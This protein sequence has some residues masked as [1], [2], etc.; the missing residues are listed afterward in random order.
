M[1][2]KSVGWEE[3]AKW[4]DQ[5]VG[6]AGHYYHQELIVPLLKSWFKEKKGSLV[7]LGCGQ[8]FFA[9]C[10]PEGW[11]YTGYDAAKSLVLSAKKRG[12]QNCFVQDLTQ[13]IPQPH[14]N[15]DVALFLLSLQDMEFPEKAI[16]NASQLVKPGKELWIVLNHPCF[17]IPRQSSWGNDENRKIQYRRVDQYMSENLIPIEIHPS[18]QNAK[19]VIHH[20][21]S[22]TILTLWLAKHGFLIES[23]QE[24][25]SNKTSTGS[26]ASMENRARKEFPLFMC[27]KAQKKQA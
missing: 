26:K 9:S 10:L 22:L 21:S 20:H 19:K 27:I 2:K 8:A 14:E 12:I 1:Q 7:D 6:D 13:P 18:K 17:R 11:K 23:I 25:T 24:L 3:G 15:F 4:Y 5:L 16:Q